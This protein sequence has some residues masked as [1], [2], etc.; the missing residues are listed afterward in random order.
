[1]SDS[2]VLPTTGLIGIN[3]QMVAVKGGQT[4]RGLE[5]K[6]NKQRKQV[7]ERQTEELEKLWTVRTV[8]GYTSDTM[9]CNANYT[10]V[11]KFLVEKQ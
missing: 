3:W 1:M 5:G 9:V 8:H 10:P 11:N 6:E 7:K 4:V 2:Q